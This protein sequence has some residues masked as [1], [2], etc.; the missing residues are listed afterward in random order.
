MLHLN[1]DGTTPLVSQ[2]VD[3]IS[4]LVS[5]QV[6]K[7]GARMP[8]IRALAVQLSVSVFTVVQAYDRLV[9]RG[10]I[11]SRASAGFFVQRLNRQAIEGG[12]DGD[13]DAE[14][15]E[16]RFD[17]IWYLKQIFESAA[18]PCKPGC[19]WLPDDHLFEDGVRRSLRRL[20]GEGL[21]LSGYGDPRGLMALR[22]LLSQNLAQEQM[23]SVSPEQV[24][25]C[26]GSSQGL[27]LATR[28]LVSPGDTVLV[29]DPG[30]PNLMNMLRFQ[31]ARLLGVPRT[32]SGYD[33]A[34]LDDLLSTE[35]PKVFF[36]QPRLQSPTGSRA[37]PAQLH[38]L[39]IL[40][41]RHDFVLVENDI[42][43]DMD[44][45]HRPSLASLGQL[46]RVIYLGSYSKTIAANLRV[47]YLIANAARVEQLA[48]LKMLAGL[49]SSEVS[50]RLVC[51][52]VEDGR[53][54]RHLRSLRER[55]AAGHE[56]V[57]GQLLGLGFELFSEPGEGMYLWARHPDLPDGR[58]LVEE[59]ARD[60]ILLGLG[61]LFT[62]AN[63]PCGWL[64][65]NVAF[66]QTE[67]V[68]RWL[69]GR[70]AG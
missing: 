17:A 6:L 31:G 42:Y 2:I 45:G 62:V 41:E 28:T 44:A 12:D 20:A 1:H 70:L 66:S 48:E 23:I 15:R 26:H 10:A 24:L 53:W 47:G 43:A 56:A 37:T 52:V 21:N 9:A 27:D 65:F 25:M 11:E 61:Q 55:L 68:W 4:Q 32:P 35:R 19:G 40:A 34:V 51:H 63:Q 14:R 5:T 16:P 39:L 69:A 30:Y 60:G 46:E 49:S 50:E 29:D 36:T 22:R 57:A 33:M 64:R 59:A 67:V 8:S 13:G 38:Q 54:R 3:G 58:A 18:T 7:P